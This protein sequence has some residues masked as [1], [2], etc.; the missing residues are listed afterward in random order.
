[1]CPKTFIRNVTF[2]SLDNPK[3]LTPIRMKFEAKLKESDEVKNIVW[4]IACEHDSVATFLY[5]KDHDNVIFVKQFRPSVFFG[6]VR[7]MSE[8]V[9]KSIHEI[10]FTKYPVSLGFSLELCAG[11]IDKPGVSVLKHAHEEIFEECG[12]NVP[13]ENIKFLKRFT[14]GIG[15]S[16]AQQHIFYAIIDDSMKVHEGGGNVEEGENIESIIMSI[17]EVK[18][19]MNED[20]LNSPPG[21]LYATQYFLD[22]IYKTIV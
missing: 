7:R 14:T 3:Y 22:Y 2:E 16:G 8:N 13:L 20:T 4:E 15:F 18:D 1:M 9:N 12:Y 21:F 5:N 17:D 11:L 6:A 10:D 19:L